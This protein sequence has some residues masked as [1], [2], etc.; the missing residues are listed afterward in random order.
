MFQAKADGTALGDGV[1]STNIACHVFRAGASVKPLCHTGQQP[2]TPETH[3]PF[4]FLLNFYSL[5]TQMP[6]TL[7]K[8]VYNLHVQVMFPFG[9]QFTA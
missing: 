6:S 5:C 8:N 2:G 9:S 3:E 4:D 1:H 7:L